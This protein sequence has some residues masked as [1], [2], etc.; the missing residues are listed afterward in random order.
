MR[1]TRAQLIARL[2]KQLASARRRCDPADR[3]TVAA[4]EHGTFVAP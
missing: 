1:E 2:T 3:P 4:F